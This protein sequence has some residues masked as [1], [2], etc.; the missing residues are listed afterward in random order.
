MYN[1]FMNE[2]EINVKIGDRVRVQGFRGVVT[3]VYHWAEKEFNGVEYID[4][5][6]TERT[7]VKVHFDGQLSC[8]GQYQDGT[9]GDFIVVDPDDQGGL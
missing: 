9:Y 4:K 3:E 5:P 2:K 7:E 6:G 8:W 1:K